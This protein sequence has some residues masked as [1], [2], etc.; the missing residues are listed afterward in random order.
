MWAM[1]LVDLIGIALDQLGDGRV[2]GGLMVDEM[3]HAGAL[4]KGDAPAVVVGIGL[5]ATHGK[6]GKAEHNV[7]RDIAV[8]S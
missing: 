4:E 2:D 5:A 7:G 6:A 1:T 3:A 8:H